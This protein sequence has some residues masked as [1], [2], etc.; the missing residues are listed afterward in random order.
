MIGALQRVCSLLLGMI[1][2]MVSNGLLV[3]LLTLCGRGRALG[4][5]DTDIGIMQ[6]T[7]P[8]GSRTFPLVY[9]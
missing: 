6:S 8:I 4:F 9:N 2:L 3:T 7:L 1:L 5:D